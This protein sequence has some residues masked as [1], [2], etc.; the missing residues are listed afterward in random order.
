MMAIFQ[1][2]FVKWVLAPVAVLCFLVWGYF[3]IYYPTIYYRFKITLEVQTPSGIKSG[4]VVN[5]ESYSFHLFDRNFMP[6]AGG[7]VTKAEALFIDLG[8]SK[9]LILTIHYDPTRQNTPTS[10][11]MGAIGQG[12][13][14][15]NC[16]GEPFAFRN[17]LS[18][19]PKRGPF[20]VDI[21]RLPNAVTLTDVNDYKSMRHLQPEAI[22]AVLGPGYA[23]KSAQLE[24][25]DEPLTEKIEQQLPWLAEHFKDRGSFD[26]SRYAGPKSSILSSIGYYSLK[27]EN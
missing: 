4:S 12:F 14:E 21:T 20:V 13:C 7:G 24:I 1:N 11:D 23:I 18:T 8:A 2:R 3:K 6:S 25:T 26:G 15:T 5:E 22:D 10:M 17:E 16:L 19:A 9:N 27:W